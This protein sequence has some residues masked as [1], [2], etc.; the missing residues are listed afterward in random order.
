[1]ILKSFKIFFGLLIILLFNLPLQSEDKI[2][3]WKNKDK[4]EISPKEKKLIEKKNID[5]INLKNS[6]AIKIDPKIEIEDNFSSDKSDQQ[7]FGIY[8]PADNNFN[9]NMWSTT[10]ADDVK[11]SL[12]DLEKLNCQKLQ[13]R[14]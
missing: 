8:D 12:K 11:S 7:I 3:I 6:Q 2:D 1:M 14:Y 4:K 13:M 5:K 9:L 10:S